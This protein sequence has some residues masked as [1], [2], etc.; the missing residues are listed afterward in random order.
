MKK[1][2]FSLLALLC[3][4]AASAATLYLT[5]NS[6]WNID[7]ARFALYT[8]DVTPNWYDMTAVAGETNLYSVEIPDGVTNVIFCRMAPDKKAN[9]WDNKWN[10]TSDLKYDGTNN[11]YTVKDG[12]WDNGGGTWSVYTPGDDNGGDNTG[13]DN[14]GG[15]NTTTTSAWT[16]VGGGING[17][18][19]WDATAG[20]PFVDED[21][22]G[23]YT[24]TLTSLE[25][26]FKVLKD[27]DW[28]GSHV[29]VNNW[30]T[31]F[32]L[33]QVFQ[34][35]NA[36]GAGNIK[37]PLYHVW[38]GVTLTL[39]TNA[40][41]LSATATED[42]DNTPTEDNWTL[43]GSDIN[44][45]QNWNEKGGLEFT[46]DDEDGV[47]TLTLESLSGEF[48]IL[49]NKTWA[50]SYI[51]MYGEG[52]FIA[53]Q[54]FVL[55]NNNNG[56]NIVME[57]GL[58]LTDV[59]LSLLVMDGTVTLWAEES[60]TSGIE[61]IEIESNEAVEYFNLQGVRVDNPENGLFIRKQGSKVAKVL[62]K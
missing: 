2:Y 6:N 33:D 50:G 34:I 31:Y 4:I 49:K 41:T 56:G 52:P 9:S 28:A 13:G 61:G 57:E 14:T 11:H 22:D 44:G 48:K 37:L 20:E 21:G 47:L 19:N 39:D 45:E 12:T 10:Q 51:L 38:N 30:D 23:I 60:S 8:W 1:I 24:L 15:D 3:S 55:E 32:A 58:T 5:P 54:E 53:G 59:T 16:L 36:D 29:L 43:V 62:V 42:I 40:L 46:D 35:E 17:S 27:A 18:A 7:N 25:G 26:E